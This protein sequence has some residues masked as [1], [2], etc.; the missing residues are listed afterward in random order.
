MNAI[1]IELLGMSTRIG[2]CKRP[3]NAFESYEKQRTGVRRLN[4][5]MRPAWQTIC[6]WDAVGMAQCEIGGG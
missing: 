6:M 4:H 1:S 5:N 3:R 2:M